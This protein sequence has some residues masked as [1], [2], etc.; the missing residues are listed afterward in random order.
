MRPY[1]R[2]R[3][4]TAAPTWG[5]GRAR[6]APRAG[7]CGAAARA[8]LRSGSSLLRLALCYVASQ[9]G[10]HPQACPVAM[11]AAPAP[12]E[13]VRAARGDELREVRLEAPAGSPFAGGVFALVVTLPPPSP[14]PPRRGAPRRARWPPPRGRAILPRR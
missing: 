6:A 8:V 4:K 9:P 13:Q 1:W 2:A 14:A 3:L 10:H 7:P 5:P 11:E 12:R